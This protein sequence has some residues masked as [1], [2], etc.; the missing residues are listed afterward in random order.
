ML[1]FITLFFLFLHWIYWIEKAKETN[2]KK[3]KSNN[4]SLWQLLEKLLIRFTGTVVTFQLVGLNIFN[5]SAGRI[6]SYFGFTLFLIGLLISVIAR[7]EIDTNWTGGYEYQIK[8]Y[9]SL[10]TTGIYRYI[11]H[12]I[13]LGLLCIALGVELVVQSYLFLFV[14]LFFFWFYYWGKREEKL[15]SE[16]FGKEYELYVKRTK[17]FIPYIF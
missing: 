2:L 14:F 6:V 1:K 4:M 12:P 10:V 15:L 9:H 11:R 16:H 13:Y 3:P 5:F 8:K 7:K 17:M